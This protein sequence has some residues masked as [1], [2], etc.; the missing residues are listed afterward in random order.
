ML[1]LAA[2]AGIKASARGRVGAGVAEMMA[3][4]AKLDNALSSDGVLT[5]EEWVRHMP[6][7]ALG[8]LRGL[9]LD[10]SKSGGPASW[11]ALRYRSLQ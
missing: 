7:D 2:G 10:R 6:P 5:A 8:I 4:L 11:R 1:G 9:G 3:Q